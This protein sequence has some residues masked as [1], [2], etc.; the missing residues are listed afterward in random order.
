MG[1]SSSLDIPGGGTEGYHVLKVHENSPGAKAGIQAFFDFIV[2]INGTRLDQDNDTFKQIL[3]SGIGKKIP[4]TL[5]STKTQKVRSVNIE[6]SDSWGGAGLIGVSIRFCSFDG[7]NENV[8]HILEVYPSSPAELA[9]LRSFTDYIISA[10]SVLHENEDLFALIEA[11]EGRNL[12]LYVYNCND[13]A[14]REVTI[15]PN[16]SWGGEGSIGCG[17]GYGYLHRIPIRDNDESQSNAVEPIIA[18]DANM[19]ISVAPAVSTVVSPT[20]E[21]THIPPPSEVPINFIIPTTSVTNENVG[22]V[23][24][25]QPAV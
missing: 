24:A 21:T 19:P 3:R 10:E 16:S 6:P 5:Y 4:I 17:I 18:S 7:A 13:D 23:N 20:V 14:C 11:H 2:A 9:G 15:T 8:W 25:N 22:L 12:K 1:N